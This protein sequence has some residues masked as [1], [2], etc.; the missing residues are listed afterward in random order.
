M[1]YEFVNPF[2]RAAVSPSARR[3]WIE[4]H[5]REIEIYK[6]ESPSARREWIEIPFKI[7]P[8]Q[9]VPAVSLREEGVD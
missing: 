6:Q 5:A 9:R 4:I 8:G 7:I 1:K 3:E 2:Q